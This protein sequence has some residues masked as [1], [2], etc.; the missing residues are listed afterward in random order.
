MAVPS[1]GCE[2]IVPTLGERRGPFNNLEAA[3]PYCGAEG[4]GAAVS[5]VP[6]PVP[7]VSPVVPLLL[8]PLLTP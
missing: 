8:V 3:F 7:M 5:E 2:G 1:G 6:R 4:R